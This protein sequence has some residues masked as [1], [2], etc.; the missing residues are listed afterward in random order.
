[1]IMSNGHSRCKDHDIGGYNGRSVF[2][3]TIMIVGISAVFRR[4]NADANMQESRKIRGKFGL[5]EDMRLDLHK[6]RVCLIEE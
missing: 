3:I 6:F 5:T 2:L 4:L 1:M